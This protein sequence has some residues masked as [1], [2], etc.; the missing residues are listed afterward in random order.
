MNDKLKELVAECYNPYSD[1]D[2]EKFANLIIE[3]VLSIMGDPKNYNR[4]TYTNFDL[5][6]ALCI[7]TELSDKIKKLYENV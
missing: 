3:D 1:F 5:N 4:C 7:S 2:Y 6:T